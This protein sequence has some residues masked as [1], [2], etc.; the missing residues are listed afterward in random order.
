MV[1]CHP[2]ASWGRER[3]L[4]AMARLSRCRGRIA[5]GRSGADSNGIDVI[6]SRPD[7][8]CLGRRDALDCVACPFSKADRARPSALG[9]SARALISWRGSEAM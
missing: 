7:R 6:K 2:Q 9:M 8:A 5:D 4:P 3:L 1:H